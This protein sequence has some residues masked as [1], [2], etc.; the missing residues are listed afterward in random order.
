MDVE[1]EMKDLCKEIQEKAELG[2][3]TEFNNTSFILYDP[4]IGIEA[5]F[6]GVEILGESTIKFSLNLGLYNT[7]IQ[8]PPIK[9]FKEEVMH[10]ETFITLSSCVLVAYGPI[11]DTLLKVRNMQG[12]FNH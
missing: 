8:V 9:I 1:K 4:V 3:I 6:Q 10:R 2:K 7:Y 11:F 5:C 12:F